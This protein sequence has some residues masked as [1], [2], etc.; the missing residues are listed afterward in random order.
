MSRASIVRRA[1][2]VAALGTA[3]GCNGDK[4]PTTGPIDVTVATDLGTLGGV[5]S[6]AYA[7][8]AAG[9]VVGGS[10]TF[11]GR[12]HAFRW[13]R[14]GGMK[15]LGT[16]PGGGSSRAVWVNEDGD[17]AGWSTTSAGATHAVVWT[18][19]GAM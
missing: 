11:S 15:D 6:R 10:L 19:Q 12:E 4:A 5:E 16:L 9:A 1:C 2:V 17:V 3:V 7:I 13:T 18:R 8:N 14:G